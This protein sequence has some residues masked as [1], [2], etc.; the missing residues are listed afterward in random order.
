M[1]PAALLFAFVKALRNTHA[2]AETLDALTTER[3]QHD[4]ER[5]RW[6]TRERFYVTQLERLRGELAEHQRFLA[7]LCG[8][9]LPET[10]REK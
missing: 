6:E 2:L 5:H 3:W 1:T 10:T 7:A 9:E 8:E 4:A